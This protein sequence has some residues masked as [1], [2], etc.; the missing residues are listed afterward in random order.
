MVGFSSI[1]AALQGVKTLIDIVSGLFTLK[2][3]A[4][5][6]EK[7]D[8][9]NTAVLDLQTNLATVL[10]ERIA[11]TEEIGALKGKL[12]SLETWSREKTRYSL[13]ESPSGAY[14]YVLKKEFASGEPIHSICPKC[15]EESKK[16]ILQKSSSD[17]RRDWVACPACKAVYKLIDPPPTPVET[18]RGRR[19]GRS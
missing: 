2:R 11:L 16:S 3:K 4:D 7:A 14:V 17:P 12:A 19:L 15:Y 13:T 9:L 8:Q 1:D 10:Q 18:N 6:R 5:I